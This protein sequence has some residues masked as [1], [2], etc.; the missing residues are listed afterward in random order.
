M[1]ENCFIINVMFREHIQNKFLKIVYILFFWS[2]LKHLFLKIFEMLLSNPRSLLSWCCWP[3]APCLSN[4]YFLSLSDKYMHTYNEFW[5]STQ[6]FFI[7][8]KKK[9]KKRK[10]V[11]ANI[12]LLF[13]L[14][15][16]FEVNL[17]RKVSE[18]P[19]ES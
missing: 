8:T 18:E 19:D 5:M 13:L 15:Q 17:F 6:G 9:N 4:H 7:N 2:I 3:T 12:K 14:F 16:L 10:I 1:N 11:I